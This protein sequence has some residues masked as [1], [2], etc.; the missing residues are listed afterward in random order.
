MSSSN[1]DEIKPVPSHATA[2]EVKPVPSE[3]PVEDPV[4]FVRLLKN[5]DLRWI[6]NP[7]RR[8][9]QP[10]LARELKQFHQEYDLGHVI[11]VQDLI[12]AGDV[13]RDKEAALEAGKLDEIDRAAVEGER[14]KSFW[15]ESKDLKVIVL[16]CF[17]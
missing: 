16:I 5:N 15:E 17:M 14:A 13:G 8:Y 1:V 6:G 2:T 12:N 7:L 9:T 11:D 3:N 4:P 10:Q